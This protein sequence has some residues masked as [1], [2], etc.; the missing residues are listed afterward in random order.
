[1]VNAP[2]NH[3]KNPIKMLEKGKKQ[4][5]FTNH[6]RQMLSP[7]MAYADFE[8]IMKRA[9]TNTEDNNSQGVLLCLQ[10]GEDRQCLCH[11]LVLWWTKCSKP[12]PDTAA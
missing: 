4:I 5:K 6:K 8:S 10:G 12:F 11:K 3:N 2:E 1:M 9:V 7:Y